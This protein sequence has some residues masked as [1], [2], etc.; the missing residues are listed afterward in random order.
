[1]VWGVVRFGKEIF[2]RGRIGRGGAVGR[3]RGR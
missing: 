3:S 1:M 2:D